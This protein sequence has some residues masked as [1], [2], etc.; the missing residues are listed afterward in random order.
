[1]N[2]EHFSIQFPR[3]ILNHFLIKNYSDE[4][5]CLLWAL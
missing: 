4:S 3:Q 1:M 2:V 5:T